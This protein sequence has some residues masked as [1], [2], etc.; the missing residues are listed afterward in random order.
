MLR[1]NARGFLCPVAII[2]PGPGLAILI[3]RRAL[4]QTQHQF[5]Q[6]E[7]YDGNQG[8]RE[9]MTPAD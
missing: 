9:L 5:F 8:G 4:R 7:E 3:D 2:D 1:F 6:S